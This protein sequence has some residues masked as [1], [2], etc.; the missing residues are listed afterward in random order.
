MGTKPS[1]ADPRL[2]I[3]ARLCQ[4]SGC[5]KY[6]NSPSVFGAHREGGACLTPRQMRQ[7]GMSRNER[8][9][10]IE[11]RWEGPDNGD[12]DESANGG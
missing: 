6:F 8:G 9:Y 1:G 3:G 7:R 2:P 10:W 12:R 11:K 5:G 4:C